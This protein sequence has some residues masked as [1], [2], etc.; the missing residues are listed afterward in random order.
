VCRELQ[1]TGMG[2]W[3]GDTATTLAATTNSSSSSSVS[4]KAGAA[5]VY[6]HSPGGLYPRPVQPARLAAAGA[7]FRSIGRLF[8]KA[9]MDGRMLDLPLALPLCARLTG[10]RHFTL[11]DVA[12]VDPA[13]ARSLQAVAELS[14]RAAAAAAQGDAVAAAAAEEEAECLC[15]TWS[16]PGYAWYELR[17]G[18]ASAGVAASE[19]GAYVTA[20]VQHL[21]VTG[22][23]HQLSQLELGFADVV[24]AGTAALHVFRPRELQ[25]LLGGECSSGSVGGGGSSTS[26]QWE[27]RAIA[28]SIVC[29]HGYTTASPQV[30][31][32]VAV[33]TELSA[34]QRRQF[35]SFVTGTPRLPVGGFA[36]LQPRLTIVRKDVPM[37][38]AH[39]PSCS[40]CQVYLKLPAYTS[41]EALRSKLLFAITE[42]QEHFA[43]D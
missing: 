34:E 32:L 25:E 15:L 22:V 39:L 43:L 1:R 42:G 5:P 29:N 37:P 8:G 40:T 35:L 41:K 18:G 6:L 31:N 26:A 19:L 14:S 11:A 21:L 10:A 9:L 7:R 24:P 13:L 16:L 12:H 30:V 33:M 17:P 23:Q 28:S 3:H 20:V 2:L 38:D 4:L 36:A 27:E